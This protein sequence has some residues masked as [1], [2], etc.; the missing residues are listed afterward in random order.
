MANTYSLIK[1][2][3]YRLKPQGSDIYQYFAR[4]SAPDLVE[5]DQFVSHMSRHNSPY[6]RGVIA[7]VLTDM[8]DCLQEL[9]LD[10]KSVRLGDLGLFSIRLTSKG[11]DTPAEFDPSQIIGVK[12][13]LTN[14]KTWSNAQLKK[15]CTF[16]EQDVYDALGR[17]EP[18]TPEGGEEGA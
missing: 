15:L 14:T 9:L 12:L 8:L 13:R 11:C 16:M 4:A 5:F 3:V 2:Q 18:A 7:G 1:Y 6:S 17:K 10:G